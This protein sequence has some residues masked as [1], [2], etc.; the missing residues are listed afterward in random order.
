[1]SDPAS[2][3]ELNLLRTN[4]A[5][6]L[7]SSAQKALI[8]AQRELDLLQEICQLTVDVGGYRM[9][10]MGYL[11]RSDG[12][13]RPV[14]SAGYE[15]GYLDEIRAAAPV[16]ALHSQTPLG[17]AL[18][19]G[20]PEVTVDPGDGDPAP[21]QPAARARGYRSVICLPLTSGIRP[22]GVLA[23]YS[24]APEAANPAELRLL[25]EM[26]DSVAFGISSL[27]ARADQQRLHAAVIE[28]AAGVSTHDESAFFAGLVQRLARVVGAEAAFVA[29]LLPGEPQKARTVAT[30]VA[31]R[32]AP[33]FE[34]LVSETP[35][36]HLMADA[37]CIAARG[38]ALARCPTAALFATLNA[39]HCVGRRLVAADGRSVGVVAVL[40]QVPPEDVEFISSILEIFATRAASELE[41][42]QAE[43]HLREQAALL[44]EAS[45]AIVHM[46]LAGTIAFWNRGAA[47]MLGW[48]A[49]EAVGRNCR[50]LLAQDAQAWA[51]AMA[52]LLENSG[53]QGEWASTTQSGRVRTLAVRWTLVRDDDGAPA[54]VLAIGTDVTERRSLEQQFLRAQRLESIGTLA[55]GIAHDLNNILSPIVMGAS[56]LR[57]SV[58][59]VEDRELLA[60]MATNSRRGTELVKQVLAFAKG[61]TGERISVDPVHLGREILKIARETFPKDIKLHLDPGPTTAIVCGDPTQLHQVL[62]N[63][64][65]NARDAMPRGGTLSVAFHCE[66]I[67]AT[68]AGMNLGSDVGDYLVITVSDTGTGMTPAVR[69][70][71]FE[72]FFTTKAIGEGT[73]LG[74]STSLAIVRSHGGFIHVYS[75]PDSGTA[76]KVYLPNTARADQSQIVTAHPTECPR[77]DG[78]WILVVDDEENIR[79]ITQAMLERYGYR[80][81]VAS[82][83][84]EAVALYASHRAEI[85]VV[86]TDMSMPVL[87]GVATIRALRAMNPGVRIIGSSGLDLSGESAR[88][89]DA[90]IVHFVA[91][92]YG[93]ETMLAM[94][95]SVLTEPAA[96]A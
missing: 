94:L 33:D 3:S 11:S 72:P 95:R 51:D 31:G 42:R 62:L 47:D 7:L 73:G 75:E 22:L 67:D 89:A 64:C 63:L 79:R 9:A 87:D 14:V 60:I 30:V 13:V 18:R 86:I 2:N 39:S 48:T 28:V 15:A 70:R 20:K 66:A 56:M 74:L 69:E 36:A 17:R 44:D 68:Y 38:E 25:Q 37:G 24:A 41:R 71:I 52:A 26:A 49:A 53:W 8:R 21:W 16:D 61:I 32:L 55:G 45:D 76:F 40:F 50:E 83:G 46:D 12:A 91:K 84:A 43:S 85:A 1:M 96:T 34:F 10:W 6:T 27:R 5:L 78:E 92:P 81:R 80:V 90:G 65:V 59:T 29:R 57:D 93:A 23:L 77:G 54:S 82:N 58:T 35:C 4:R 88:A 19:S